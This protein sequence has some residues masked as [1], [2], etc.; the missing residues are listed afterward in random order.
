MNTRTAHRERTL[1][2]HRAAA[3]RGAQAAVRYWTGGRGSL[4]EQAELDASLEIRDW[5]SA[6]RTIRAQQ[7]T[8]AARIGTINGWHPHTLAQARTFYRWAR[9]QD[10]D[11]QTIAAAWLAWYLFAR[12]ISMVALGLLR[13]AQVI[14]P[15][16]T[17]HG[18]W[19][20]PPLAAAPLITPRSPRAPAR[21]RLRVA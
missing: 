5:R 4:V 6:A 14:P 21:T 16:G 3:A 17:A 18:Y 8:A 13:T 20:P 1:D 10:A 7:A 2:E 11:I 19:P 9:H 12:L 15:A